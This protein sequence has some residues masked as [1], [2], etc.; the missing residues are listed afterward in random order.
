MRMDPRLV[1]VLERFAEDTGAPPPD[2]VTERA[3]E[4]KEAEGLVGVLTRPVPASVGW[5]DT[6]TDGAAAVPVRIYTPVG[7]G[8]RTGLIYAHGGAWRTGS[9]ATTH[10]H[11]GN[12]AADADAIVVSVDYRLIPEHPYPAG[13][14]DVWEVL[15]WVAANAAKLGIDPARL[16]IGGSSAG[17]NLAA[18][19]ALRA[20]DQSGPAIALQILEAAVLDLHRVSPSWD[21][22]RRDLPPLAAML[23]RGL[24]L[25]LETG[26]D[27]D[28]P[29]CAPLMAASFEKLPPAVLLVGEAD[30]LRHDSVR[31]AE[32]LGAAG[33]RADLHVFPGI[34]HGTENFVELMPTAMEWHRTCVAA[35]TALA[36]GVPPTTDVSS[37]PPQIVGLVSG[38]GLTPGVLL[39]HL[40]V[41]GAAEDVL[42]ASTLGITPAQL[43]G[44]RT[45]FRQDLEHTA[46]ELLADAG[47]VAELEKLPFRTGERI[48]VV[49]DSISA[50][51][52]SW[53]NILAV[54]LGRR[55]IEL[56]NRAVSGRSSTDTLAVFD[57][58]LAL[59]PD[60]ILL[61]I[62]ANDVRRHGTELGVRLL[63]LQESV[64]TIGDLVRMATHG[65]RAKV[66][67][68]PS[69]P[70][71]DPGR[72]A[73][74]RAAGIFWLEEDLDE[75]NRVLVA[76]VPGAI[77]I[78]SGLAT[79]ADYWAPDGV[80]PSSE[81]QRVLLRAIVHALAD[82]VVT[83]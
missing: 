36:P 32:A 22:A 10:E 9:P 56:T 50:A 30:P 31:Y 75:A 1:P 57:H 64:R 26:A 15:R 47:F 29:Y 13:I 77:D 63:S 54:L 45:G 34:V 72:I 68:M 83:R 25:Y 69:H 24:S 19:V 60:W 46:D 28:D 79:S 37:I 61:T 27:A 6:V 67:T 23:D 33:V 43:D 53:A 39:E 40:G 44:L 51:A 3:E 74:N 5:V 12:L 78:R 82:P 58:T 8:V 52:D 48:A 70:Q 7:P 65:S 62:G 80:H 21:E 76:A 55:G 73:A 81:G 17:G 41:Q 59:D 18:A 16:A 38:A 20:R 2:P 35:L 11:A 42:I 4:L 14:D 66:V 71:I 49:G